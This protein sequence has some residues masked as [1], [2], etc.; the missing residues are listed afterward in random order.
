MSPDGSWW[1]KLENGT[2]IILR[3]T[4]IHYQIWKDL[5]KETSGESVIW[6][7]PAKF[8]YIGVIPQYI[9]SSKILPNHQVLAQQK[10]HQVKGRCNYQRQEV[11]NG[12]INIFQDAL[13]QTQYRC[14]EQPWFS[15][16]KITNRQWFFNIY[17]G[18][19]EGI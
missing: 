7:K 9:A 15:V 12:D 14:A 2:H 13:G 18:L 17:V 19:Q 8:G 5:W 11:N 10:G 4:A 3:L 16:R 1:L 6:D